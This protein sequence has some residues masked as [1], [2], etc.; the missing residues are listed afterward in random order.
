MSEA[1]RPLLFAEEDSE[2]LA[3]RD[4]VAPATRSEEALAKASTKSLD[5]GSPVHSFRTLLNEL[6]TLVRNTCRR[7][8]ADDS[9]E[10]FELDTKPNPKQLAAFDRLKTIR[11]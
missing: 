2:R 8:N 9:E 4:P 11:V 6:A 7:K 5:D 3:R 10:T 1:W